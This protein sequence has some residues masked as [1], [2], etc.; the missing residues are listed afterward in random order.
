HSDVH[1]WYHGTIDW[2]TPAS[3]TEASITSSERT[4]WWVN[5]ESNGVTAGFLYSLIGGADRTGTNRPLGGSFPAIRDGYDQ[6]WD[7]GA[8][9]SSN[10]VN[11]STN[12]GGWPNLIRLNR[13]TTNQLLAGQSMPVRF[14]YQWARSNTTSATVSIYLDPDLNPLNGNQV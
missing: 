4:N 11:I 9:T 7:L 12:T 13:T 1:L 3:D 8:G 2:R 14:Y 10:R 6:W 5:T